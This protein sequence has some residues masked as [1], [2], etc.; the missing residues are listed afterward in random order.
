MEVGDV[1]R[2][3]KCGDVEVIGRS[4][5]KKQYF[6]IKFLNT[7]NIVERRRDAIVSGQVIDRGSKIRSKHGFGYTEGT[8]NI[9]VEQVAHHKWH[10]MIERCYDK[11][12][13]SYDLYGGAGITVC[14][15]WESF[16]VFFKW[17][18]SQPNYKVNGMEIDKDLKG[19]MIYSPD[20][21][22]LLPKRLNTAM[23]A[24]R[25]KNSNL[26]VGVLRTG[27]KFA[28]GMTQY[29]KKFHVGA[30]SS[31]EEASLMYKRAKKEYIMELAEIELLNG[32]I[33]NEI[34]ELI[35]NYE[36]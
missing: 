15:E 24:R 21:C 16:D 25:K 28:A 10:H 18:I 32:L 1:Y 2:S 19:G 31:A 3:F 14:D 7:G 33:S 8:V 4:E 30:Y 5:K 29:G 11:S 9:K 23:I 36:V 13:H 17:F 22:V 6:K 20:N 34:F 26:P 35:N 27:K 12:Y